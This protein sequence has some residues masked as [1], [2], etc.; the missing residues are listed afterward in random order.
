MIYGYAH[1]PFMS[2]GIGRW[3]EISPEN[4]AV[5]QEMLP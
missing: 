4:P 3:L 1:A 2:K 5:A